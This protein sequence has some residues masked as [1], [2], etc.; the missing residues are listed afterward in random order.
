MLALIFGVVC[1][2]L[3]FEGVA[4][5]ISA[6]AGVYVISTSYYK[7]YLNVDNDDYPN[8]ELSSEGMINSFGM[9]MVSDVLFI[10]LCAAL[11]IY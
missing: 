9:F 6:M 4:V 7:T 10:L 11:S 3:H 2:L 5:I 8:N 1:G